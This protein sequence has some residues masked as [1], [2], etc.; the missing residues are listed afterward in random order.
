MLENYNAAFRNSQKSQEIS[1]SN[2]V[3]GSNNTTTAFELMTYTKNNPYSHLDK[4][5]FPLHI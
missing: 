2:T 5:Y 4:Y 3:E 1:I